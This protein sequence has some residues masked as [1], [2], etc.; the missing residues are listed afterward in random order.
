MKMLKF[1]DTKYSWL[2][3]T[4]TLFIGVFLNAGMWAVIAIMP[5]F[6]QE[7]AISRSVSSAQFALNMFGFA[8]GNLFIGRMMDKLGVV[9]TV[10]FAAVISS[11][12]YFLCTYTVNIYFLSF[13]HLILGIGTSLWFRTTYY[14]YISLVYKK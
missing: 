4:L 8:I 5:M 1:H 14:R 9:K 2:R 12:S 13:L 6:E 7:L 11:V 3:L 10:C